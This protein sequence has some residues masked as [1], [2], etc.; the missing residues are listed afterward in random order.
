MS[1]KVSK[2]TKV[3]QAD[4]DAVKALKAAKV[5]DTAISKILSRATSTVYY[6]GASDSLE[7]YHSKT[8]ARNEKAEAQPD[9]VDEVSPFADPN[10]L[11]DSPYTPATDIPDPL[12]RIAA[13]LERLADAWEN[14]KKKGWIK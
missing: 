13:A 6:L 5:K 4:F 14:P 7:D 9:P 8:Q 11:N 10:P 2:G 1:K 3:T 12:D